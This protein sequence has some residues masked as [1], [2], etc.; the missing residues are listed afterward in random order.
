MTALLSYDD[1]KAFALM[2]GAATVNRIVRTTPLERLRE[3][4]FG[5]WSAVQVLGHLAD[6]AD[7]FAERVRRAVEEDTP[8]LE[9]IPGGSGADPDADPMAL[10]RRL[11]ASHQRVVALL[12]S[13]GAA[14]RPAVHSEWGRVTA[15]HIAAYLAAH[16]SEHTAELGPA[17]PPGS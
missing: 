17:F 15:G 3:R 12:R 4:R 9:A 10:A 14:E 2:D 7:V 1:D 6:V 8:R 13:P 11:L 5:E 16:S